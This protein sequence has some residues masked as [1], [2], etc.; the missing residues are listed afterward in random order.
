[1]HPRIKTA[2]VGF[3]GGFVHDQAEGAIFVVVQDV[4]HSA[5]KGGLVEQRNGYKHVPLCGWCREGR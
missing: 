2:D 5:M 4:D 3:G 1:M